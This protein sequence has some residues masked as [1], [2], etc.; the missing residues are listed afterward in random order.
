VPAA[1]TCAEA[2]A[3]RIKTH[4]EIRARE[5]HENFFTV[6]LPLKKIPT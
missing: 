2:Q 4:K 5:K 6:E 1:L 3:D